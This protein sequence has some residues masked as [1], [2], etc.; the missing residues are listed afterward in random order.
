MKP[1]PLVFLL[2]FALPALGQQ[3][4]F[5]PQR[6]FRSDALFPQEGGAP[7]VQDQLGTN[8][9]LQFRRPTPL[10]PVPQRPSPE[11][12]VFVQPPSGPRG[13]GAGNGGQ[14]TDDGANVSDA[15]S[16]TNSA[17]Q[18][19]N[20]NNESGSFNQQSPGGMNT[21]QGG[22]NNPSGG[23][24]SAASVPAGSGGPVGR[25]S[26]NYEADFGNNQGNVKGGLLYADDTPTHSNPVIN[27]PANSALKKRESQRDQSPQGGAF[28]SAG[29]GATPSAPTGGGTSRPAAL[30]QAQPDGLLDRLKNIAT[31]LGEKFFG[32]SGSGGKNNSHK[33]ISRNVGAAA[34]N[35]SP[36]QGSTPDMRGLLQ[37]RLNQYRGLASQLEFA[38]SNTHLFGNMCKHYRA[39]A[40]KH[41]IPN[42]E[43]GCPK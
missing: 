26:G 30:P 35:K 9:G 36:S 8:L 15:S 22:F 29:A 18:G 23:G 33:G 5:D 1:L 32:L 40:L 41:R 11:R 27:N 13:I 24:I 39:Y 6:V 34:N 21:A 14:I 17:E 16:S 38:K 25:G 12:N 43:S 19:E 37:Q 3:P 7:N 10:P 28:A 4:Q 2:F 31:N 20:P 42:D